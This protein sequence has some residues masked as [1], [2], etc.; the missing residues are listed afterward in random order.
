M[1]VMSGSSNTAASL[2]SQLM[3]D[4]SGE[5]LQSLQNNL[6]EAEKRICSLA[7]G[8]LIDPVQ[9]EVSASLPT[10]FAAAQDILAQ[11]GLAI[12]KA[13]NTR[14]TRAIY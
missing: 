8:R 14:V 12:Q 10:V 13:R 2:L 11:V 3:A 1:Y 7:D 6:D 9:Q 4:A 5:M